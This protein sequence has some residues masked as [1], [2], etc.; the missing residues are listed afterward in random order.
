LPRVLRVGALDGAGANIIACMNG[1]DAG[2]R[3]V[4]LTSRVIAEVRELHDRAVELE[5]E[6][7]PL[8]GRRARQ[9][10]RGA[11]VAEGDLLRVL[12]F[13][14]FGQFAAAVDEMGAQTDLGEPELPLGVDEGDEGDAAALDPEQ[15]E[16]DLIRALHD[17][18]AGAGHVDADAGDSVDVRDRVEPGDV[19][20]AVP[21]RVAELEEQLEQARF[22]LRELRDELD[23]RTEMRATYETSGGD[24]VGAVIEAA[25]AGMLQATEELRRL[26][27]LFREEREAIESLG[28]RARVAAEEILDQARADAQRTRDEAAAHACAV[29]DQAR[30][31][32]I[33]LTRSA[34][35]TVDGLRRLAAEGD[36]IP[37][38]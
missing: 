22:E 36:D 27:E 8:S 21:D 5:R 32:A 25:A 38:R 31:A 19:T 37:T 29:L 16:A 9:E 23:A 1:A 33:E 3:G 11:R 15:T 17:F 6:T 12:G 7:G 14:S 4:S 30:A 2:V 20:D 34:S 28:A 13:A 10:L 35:V 18:H 24:G 26:G